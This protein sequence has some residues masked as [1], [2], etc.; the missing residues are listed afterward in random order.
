MS[1]PGLTNLPANKFLV[2]CI[3]VPRTRTL[4]FS[5]SISQIAMKSR[6]RGEKYLEKQGVC[7]CGRQ[8]D[9]GQRPLVLL[10]P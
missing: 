9:N 1:L 4:G 7:G 10:P 2:K 3:S 6:Q 5:P 8:Q